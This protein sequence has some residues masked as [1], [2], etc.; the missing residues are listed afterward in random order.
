MFNEYVEIDGVEFKRQS[1]RRKD[2]PLFGKFFY[3]RKNTY[4]R[5]EQEITQF[6]IFDHAKNHKIKAKIDAVL[7]RK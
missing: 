1:E 3:Y 7:D 5:N 4:I 6:E 2:K